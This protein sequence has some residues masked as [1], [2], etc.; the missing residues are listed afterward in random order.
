MD[1]DDELFQRLTHIGGLVQ[2]L[3]QA[4]ES[5]L[6]GTEA[7]AEP[8]HRLQRCFDAGKRVQ[9]ARRDERLLAAD[10]ARLADMAQ[11]ARALCEAH[12]VRG[13]ALGTA[14]A[15]LHQEALDLQRLL[16]HQR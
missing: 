9:L 6:P 5:R 4:V 15:E 13:R 3:V 11:Q 2:R 8:V 16:P 7:L 14:L 10:L 1:A 12:R